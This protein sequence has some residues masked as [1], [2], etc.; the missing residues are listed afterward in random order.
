MKKLNY[1]KRLSKPPCDEL[2][3]GDG[4]DPRFINNKYDR[5]G[6]NYQNDRLCKQI[7]KTLMLIF[8]GCLMDSGF[9]GLFVD[10][11]RPDPDISSLMVTIMPLYNDPLP[12]PEKIKLFLESVKGYLRNEVAQEISRKR[13]PDFKFSIKIEP[14]NFIK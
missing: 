12:D 11:V 13:M 2:R 7:E 10:S 1:R 9:D 5:C 3:E 6:Q 8:S 4:I 14:E